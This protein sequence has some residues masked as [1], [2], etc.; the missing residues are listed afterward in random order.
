MYV[1]RKALT[2]RVRKL[3]RYARQQGLDPA[4]EPMS[5][6]PAVRI[7][8]LAKRLG[9]DLCLAF[10]MDRELGDPCSRSLH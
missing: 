5:K 8:Q 10:D 4:L 1:S 9:I 6:R 3:E 7:G 2:E